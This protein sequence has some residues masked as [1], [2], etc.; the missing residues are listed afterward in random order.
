MDR[1]DW[2]HEKCFSAADEAELW[3]PRGVLVSA[4]APR[5]EM[6]EMERRKDIRLVCPMI[7]GVLSIVVDAELQLNTGRCQPEF[8]VR[9]VVVVDVTQY[10]FE[11][12]E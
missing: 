6:P 11:I 4:S 2:N 10:L 5:G 7:S 9:T 1:C 8:E 3:P 12:L